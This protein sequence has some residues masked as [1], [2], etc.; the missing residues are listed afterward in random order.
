VL[1]NIGNHLGT[2]V[3]EVRFVRYLRTTGSFLDGISSV[4]RAKRRKQKFENGHQD[5]D[6]FMLPIMTELLHS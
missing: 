3:I 1:T 6:E 5:W 4:T 2:K